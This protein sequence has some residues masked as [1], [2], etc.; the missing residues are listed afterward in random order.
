VALRRMESEAAVSRPALRLP[1]AHLE[2]E[3]IMRTVAREVGLERGDLMGPS[4]R[5]TTTLA[6]H[7][8]MWLC[9]VRTGESYSAIGRAFWRD[10]TTVLA[11]VEGIEAQRERHPELRAFLATCEAALDAAK[12][13]A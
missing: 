8:A 13:G 5:A 6:R 10:H 12:E 1:T 2:V 3:R 9:R 7:A 11:A 4:R